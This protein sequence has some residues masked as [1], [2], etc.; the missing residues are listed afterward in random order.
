MTITVH[1]FGAE[2]FSLTI[3]PSDSPS[4]EPDGS[5]LAGGTLAAMPM[6]FVPR[7]EI[8][9]DCAGID[10]NNGWGDEGNRL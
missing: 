6:G 10:R 2:V 9:D 7:M 8:P 5:E 3:G 4:P 1:R